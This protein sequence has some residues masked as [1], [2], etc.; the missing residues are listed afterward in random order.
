MYFLAYPFANLLLLLYNYLGHNTVV[1]IAALTILINVLLFPLTLSQQ[2]STRRTQELQPELEK[3]KKKYGKDQERMAQEQM[4]LYREKGVNPML[5][6]L[7]LLIQFPIWFGLYRAIVYCVPN[8]PLDMFQFS[9][10]IYKWLPGVVGLVPLQSTFLGMDLG[11]PPGAAH[12]GWSQWLSYALPLLVGGTSILQQRL[13]T[14]PTSKDDQSQAATMNRQMQIMMPLMFMMFTLS[15]PVGL[16]IYFIISNLI[17]IVQ[18]Y[19]MQKNQN[20]AQAK[21]KGPAQQK[22]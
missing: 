10:H 3:L 16:S 15:Y 13:I 4:K 1:A 2:K 19:L 11:Q 18:Y 9:Q 14:P 22:S 6:C 17:R 21:S 7:P 12:P 5:G 20:D 8:T